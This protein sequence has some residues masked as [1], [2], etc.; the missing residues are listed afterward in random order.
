MKPAFLI[1]Y[2][3]LSL[4]TFY[5]Q[6]AVEIVKKAQDLLYAKSSYS[7][8]KMTIIKPEW[9]RNLGMKVWALEP[10]YAMIY[11]TEPARDKGTVTLK[12]KNEIWNWLPTIQ[13]IIKIPPSM[14]NQSWMG[15]DFTNDDLVRSSSYENDYTHKLLGEE[16]INDYICYKIESIPKPTA[17]IVWSKVISYITKNSYM[18]LKSEFYDE[19]NR[20][21]KIFIGS[22]IKNI[23]GR[24]LPTRWEMIPLDKPNNKTV[25]EYSK[26]EFNIEINQSFF[27]Q[28]NMTR[29]R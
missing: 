13:R 29:V 17:G 21:V 20:L 6:S 23:G 19:E 15:S 8:M 10:D 16:K 22:E 12:R 4:D 11:I 28:Q 7:E 25:I 1:L 24:T 9:Q 5:A 27:S 2:L 26:I 14:M 3:L 18:Q